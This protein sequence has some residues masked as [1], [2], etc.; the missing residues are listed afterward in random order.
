MNEK[1]DEVVFAYQRGDDDAAETLLEMFAGD[2]MRSRFIGKYIKLLKHEVFDLTDK[3]TRRFLQLYMVDGRDAL[4]NRYQSKEGKAAAAQTAAMLARALHTYDEEELVQDLVMLLLTQAQRYEKQKQQVN[5]G[6]YLY[7]SFRFTVFNHLKKTTFRYDVLNHPRR[8]ELSEE[9]LVVD[10]IEVDEKWFD[11]HEGRFG[12]AE[13]LGLDW[14]SGDCNHAF[15]ELSQ[16]ERL[17]LRLAYE[18]KKTDSEIAEQLGF[19]RN[20]V[21]KYRHQAKENLQGAIERLK[22]EDLFY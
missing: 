11:C 7:N 12:D 9:M 14:V 8:E 4:M 13:E 19:H 6:G 5:F 10:G 15:A 2:D 18:D 22:E 16:L 21:L 3:D 17:I 1:V 20:T